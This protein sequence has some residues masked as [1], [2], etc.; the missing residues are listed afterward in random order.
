MLANILAQHPDT[1]V[2]GTSPLYACV[3]ALANAL[4]NSPDVVSELENV[5]G[6]YERYLASTRAFVQEWHGQHDVGT[7]ID[8]HRAWPSRHGLIQ[9]LDPESR[10]ICCVRDPREIV[11]SFERQERRTALFNSPVHRQM[12]DYASRVMAPEGMVG[13]PIKLMEDLITRRIDV[14]WVRYESFVQDPAAHLAE[15]TATLGL[16]PFEFDLDNIER[17]ATDLDAIYRNKYPHEGTGVLKP[18]SGSWREVYTEDLG[19]LIAGVYP[20]FMKVFNYT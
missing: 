1:H 15:L 14:L 9:Q 12:Y 10:L 5:P 18:P 20:K 19:E 11:A 17:A 8:K 16:E 6:S 2:T 13:G 3:D 4:S 7:V